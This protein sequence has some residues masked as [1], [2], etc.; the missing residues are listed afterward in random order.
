[1]RHTIRILSFL[2]GRAS[3]NENYRK[4]FGSIEE[5]PKIWTV[6]KFKNLLFHEASA[7]NFPGVSKSLISFESVIA[8]KDIYPAW[9]NPVMADAF[10]ELG[11]EYGNKNTA[12]HNFN[13]AEI[14]FFKI[15]KK[16]TYLQENHPERLEAI[17]VVLSVAEELKDMESI[18]KLPKI[19]SDQYVDDE[20]IIHS[21]KLITKWSDM[22][23][24]M[25]EKNI[26]AHA[27]NAIA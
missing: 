10:C 19:A 12:N 2:S 14:D 24:F 1:M 15:D 18:C 5:A 8:Y 13:F 25:N 27:C 16:I 3:D 21:Q 4:L 7:V 20:E 11:V 26:E 23:I 6:Q 17:R 9:I 22:V